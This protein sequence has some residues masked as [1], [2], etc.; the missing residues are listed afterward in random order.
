MG[1]QVHRTLVLQHAHALGQLK[2][3]LRKN[4]PH[5]D[6][7]AQQQLLESLRRCIEHQGI[8]D[9]WDPDHAVEPRPHKLLL[10]RAAYT[11]DSLNVM[12]RAGRPLRI[13]EILEEL[14]RMYRVTLN[15]KEHSHATQKLAEANWKLMQK[16][17]VV[18]VDKDPNSPYGACLYALR[19]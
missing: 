17:L 18:R 19:Q 10:A 13:S 2:K 1:I 14:C 4:A 11:R 7:L 12:R 8:A 3:L 9:E 5:G 16:G 15:R 6:I